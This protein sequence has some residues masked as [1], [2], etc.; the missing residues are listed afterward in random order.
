MEH[1]EVDSTRT[2]AGAVGQTV[3]GWEVPVYLFLG[4][5]TAGLLIMVSAVVLLKGQEKVT[6]A[7]RRGLLIAPVALSLGML[8]LFVDLSYKLHVYRF[9]MTLEPTAPMSFGSWVLILVYPVLGLLILALPSALL[10]PWLERLPLTRRQGALR[11]FAERIVRTMAGIGLAGGVAL[12]I[13]TG[14]LLAVTVAHPLWSSG[15][16]GLMF[17]TS[18]FIAGVSVLSLLETDPEAKALLTVVP[19]LATVV[20]LVLVASWI[21]GLLTQGPVAR[22]AAGTLLWGPYAPVFLGFVV[23]GGM[24]VPLTL[25]G[26]ASFGKASHSRAVPVIALV[27]GFLLR[28][29]IVAAGQ[30][31][32]FPAA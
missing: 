19:A 20:E 17:L 21:I 26:L 12:G 28:V 23:F 10:E 30:S 18:G 3:W 25:E 15:A 11:S 1:I 14:V 32:G 5:V 6:E 27:G 9:Y 29:V 2:L 8:A 16:L 13:Y 31:V 24:I 7:M 22:A 4:G